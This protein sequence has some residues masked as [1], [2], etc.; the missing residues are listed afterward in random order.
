MKAIESKE[1]KEKRAKRNQLIVAVVMAAI[2]LVSSL[3]YSFYSK[4]DT[5]TKRVKYGNTIFLL[6]ENGFWQ[7][8]INELDFTTRFNPSELENISIP[9]FISS[10]SY[11]NKPLY[12]VSES[13]QEKE[14]VTELARS[15]GYF[16]SRMQPSCVEGRQ[17]LIEDLPVKNCSD[18]IIILTEKNKTKIWKEDNCV[19][20]ESEDLV[21]AADAFIFKVLGIKQ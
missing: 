7:T 6:N 16:S 5:D 19:F 14:A 4:E 15:L 2:L 1:A 11:L 8:T 18:N 3:G 17:C 13:A 21:R 10:N 20:I 12:L 9:L